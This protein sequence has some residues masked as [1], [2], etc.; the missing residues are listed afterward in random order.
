MELARELGVSRV[1]RELGIG[2]GSL[3]D[4]LGGDGERG[5]QAAERFVEIDGGSRFADDSGQRAGGSGAVG[6]E[7]HDGGDPAGR[8]AGARCGGAGGRRSAPEAGMIQITPQMRV[9]VAV[10]PAD[11]RAASTAWPRAAGRCCG[12]DP[13]TGTVFVFRNRRA[14]GDQDPG[15]RRAGVLALP[16][17][18]VERAFSPGGRRRAPRR[19]AALQAH[20]LQVLLRG[21]RPARRRRPR[22]CGGR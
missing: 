2:Y 20:E 7:W 18:V 15:L 16:Q 12:A 17:A 1:A 14:H 13:F 8:G 11:F 6:C 19:D 21:G 22:P 4:R 9:L 3:K 10:E 5:L